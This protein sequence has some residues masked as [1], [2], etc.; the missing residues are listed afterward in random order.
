MKHGFTPLVLILSA[1]CFTLTAQTPVHRSCGTHGEMAAPMMDRLL[2]NIE[3]LRNQPIRYRDIIYVPIKFHLVAKTDG[4]GRVPE[5]RVLDQLCALNEDYLPMNVQFYLKNGTF[6]Y[7]NNTTVYSTHNSTVNTIMSFARDNSALNIFIVDEAEPSG[8]GLGE[9]LGYYSP[10]KDWVVVRRD[11]VSAT[12]STLPHELGHFFSLAHPFNGWD[13]EPY[14]P[15]VHGIPA[16]AISPGGIPTE[17]ADGSNCATA[18]D[19]VCD[20]PADYNLGYGWPNCNYTGGALDP[21]SML[22]D[23]EERLFMGYFLNCPRDEYFFSPMQQ[24]LILEDLDSPQRNYVTPGYVPYQVELGG[25]PELIAPIND[26]VTAGYNAV[27]LQW[28]GVGGATRY[29]LEIDQSP[30]FSST[31]AR[32]VVNGTN[33]ILTNLVANKTYYWHVRPYGEY[34]TCSTFTPNGKFKTGTVTAAGE[35]KL[36]ENWSVDPNPASSGQDLSISISTNERLEGTISVL[37]AV[38]QMVYRTETLDLAQGDHD[39]LVPANFLSRGVYIV[40]LET[41]D[42]VLTKRVVIGD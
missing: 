15:S 17:K 5:S 31:T 33:K 20:T 2:Q 28:T 6:N 26:E 16:P 37:N 1:A 27:N 29:L 40:A 13:H 14:D 9:T 18:G 11:E 3:S 21:M 41:N 36:V 42:I 19:F 34:H 24:E 39:L 22:V 4:T 8:G 35:T 10:N 12:S 25:M 38:G 23:P 7:I 30:N 32:Y